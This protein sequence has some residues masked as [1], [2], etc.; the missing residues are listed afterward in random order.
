LSTTNPIWPD[1]GSNSG[2]RGGNI[3]PFV[4]PWPLFQLLDVCTVDR[5]PWT[6]DQ[7]VARS[8]PPHRINDSSGIRTHDPGVWASTARLQWSPAR[9]SIIK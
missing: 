4:G 5:T 2:R 8:L 1:P 3:Q 9:C 6:R 7:L